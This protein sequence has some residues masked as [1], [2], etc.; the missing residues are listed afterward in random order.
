MFHC[1]VAWRNI[2]FNVLFIIFKITAISVGSFQIL[3]SF[4]FFLFYSLPPSGLLLLK[5]LMCFYTY[6]DFEKITMNVN[7]LMMLH[8]L[9]TDNLDAGIW[10]GLIY[11]I[12]FPQYLTSPLFQNNT[13]WLIW[14]S[15][16]DWN[17]QCDVNKGLLLLL[18]S[19]SIMDD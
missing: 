15:Y 12:L 6:R 8:Q 16:F 1:L 5:I 4:T 2:S 11:F 9:L 17:A 7:V 3:V 10:K 19:F 13:S 18:L 14:N